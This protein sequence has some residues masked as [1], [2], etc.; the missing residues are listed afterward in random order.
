[1]KITKS[2][3]FTLALMFVAQDSQAQDANVPADFGTITEAL[4]FGTDA[5]LDG[6]FHVSVAPGTYTE[7]LFVTRSNVWLEGSGAATTMIQG[8][9]GF[10]AVYVQGVMSFEMSG[11]TVT[12]DPT[13]DGI[14]LVACTSASIHDNTVTGTE[15][16][17]RVNR[18][19]DVAI[20]SNMV[21]N[22]T[23]TGI[24]VKGGMQT[25]VTGNVCT[26]NFSSGID[27]DRTVGAMVTSNQSL[28]NRG[29]GVRVRR[30]SQ[31]AVEGNTCT[32]NLSNG[33]FYRDMS[34]LTVR[35]NTSTGSLQNGMR[36]RDVGS[37]LFTDNT[38]TGNSEWGIRRRDSFGN[39]WDEAQAG[40]Q[41][42][43]G[44]NDV[45]GNTLGTVRTD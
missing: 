27:L 12:G 25:L 33:M 6:L 19:I 1:M 40:S 43:P 11:F 13:R 15:D 31:V 30:S 21:A 42:A 10:R 5:N 16:G 18:S 17:I 3:L 26:G 35:G 37:S 20:S 23:S 7:S 28:M 41:D 32:G 4:R 22:N 36:I 45:S 8:D 9:M 44:S 38:L 39:D 24:K 14:E 34:Q 2:I 29:N